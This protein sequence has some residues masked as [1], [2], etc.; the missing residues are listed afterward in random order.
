MGIVDDYISETNKYKLSHGDKTVVLMQCGSFFEVYGLKDKQG[1][2]T[3]S[4]LEKVSEICEVNIAHKKVLA[5]ASRS[6]KKTNYYDKLPEDYLTFLE[7]TAKS[8]KNSK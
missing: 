4:D 6:L 7:T 5:K 8:K 1:N 2:I 3:G